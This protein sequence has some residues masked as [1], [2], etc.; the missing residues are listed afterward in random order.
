M[1]TEEMRQALLRAYPGL[2]WQR[3]VKEMP[4]GQVFV[5][6]TRLRNTGKL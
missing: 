3:K 4:D 6:Y 2:R 5:V 1:T